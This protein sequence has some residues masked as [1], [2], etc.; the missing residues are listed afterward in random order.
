M[1]AYVRR[2][3]SRLGTPKAITATAHTLARILSHT[4]RY[5]RASVKT[6]QAA[7]D[8][9]MRTRQ[10]K[11]LKRQAR[12]LGFEVVERV[13]PPHGAPEDHESAPATPA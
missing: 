7:Y 13:P 4:L 9:L 8:V 1:G 12:M 10:I 3:Q 11:T 6:T 2:M 5:G